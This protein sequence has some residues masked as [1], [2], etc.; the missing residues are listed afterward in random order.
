MRL[1]GGLVSLARSPR[2]LGGA[3]HVA[4]RRAQPVRASAGDDKTLSALDAL[5]GGDVKEPAPS[6][7]ITES[8]VGPGAVEQLERLVQPIAVSEEE[9]AALWKGLQVAVSDL[10]ALPPSQRSLPGAGEEIL[11]AL[12][13]LS[14]G[15]VATAFDAATATSLASK[16]IRDLRASLQDLKVGGIK[17]PDALG[18]ASTRNEATFLVATFLGCAVPAT[19]AGYVLPGDWGFFVPYLVGGIPIVVL[20]IGST[21]PGLLQFAIDRVNLVNPDYKQRA[22]RHE[23]GHFLCSYLLGVPVTGYSLAIGA[24]HTD[25]L[26]QKLGRPVF[27]G[28][29][30]ME[31]L[32]ALAIISMAGVAAEG[33]HYED[34]QGQTADLV[35]LQT[36]LNRAQD[37]VSKEQQLSI[38]RWATLNA[39]KLIRSN[40]SEYAALMDAMDRGCSVVDCIKAIEKAS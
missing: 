7:P 12:Q 17:Q 23:A 24:T 38:T 16:E 33:L 19:I 20:A 11:T 22:L 21:A 4:A 34:V 26:A 13:R 14:E 15:G 35:D 3:S 29:L 40:R 18:T 1:R 5:L 32:Q 27:Q 8:S 2:T 37:P 25:L 28:R 10:Q 9:A 31:E 30:N 6:E 36:I 39:A